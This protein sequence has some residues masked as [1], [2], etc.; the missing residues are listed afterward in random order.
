MYVIPAFIP[1]FA[2]AANCAVLFADYLGELYM[3]WV[4]GF[5]GEK[6]EGG[7]AGANS[8]VGS[9]VAAS[10][11][12]FLESVGTR[13]IQMHGFFFLAQFALET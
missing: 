13:L 1:V 2:C 10:R 8:V 11:I 7:Q 5:I 4:V 3:G 9:T 12:D 6:R